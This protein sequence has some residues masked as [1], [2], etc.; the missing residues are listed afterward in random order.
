MNGF[1]A[2]AMLGGAGATSAAT[3]AVLLSRASALGLWAQPDPTVINHV[4]P[5]PLLGG[6]GILAGIL[7]TALVWR[8][9]PATSWSWLFAIAVIGSLG[10]WKDRVGRPV[11]PLLQLGLQ[12]IALLIAIESIGEMRF[13]DSVWIDRSLSVLTGLWL[14]NSVNFLDVMDGLAGGVVLVLALAAAWLLCISGA[15]GPATIALCASGSIAGFLI[16]NRHPARV[17]MGD[18]GSFGLGFVLFTLVSSVQHVHGS[19]AGFLLGLV[20][21]LELASSSTIRLMKRTS[22][23]EGD[24]THLALM[25]LNRAWPV[26]SIVRLFWLITALSSGLAILMAR[27]HATP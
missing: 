14:L 24:G 13:T 4:R 21:M 26:R 12:A 3:I 10:W 20:P 11:S 2:M 9:A 16:F 6:I 18:V 19:T 22:P 7:A 1:A 5:V 17:F 23:L 25:L 8:A 27:Q 15:D